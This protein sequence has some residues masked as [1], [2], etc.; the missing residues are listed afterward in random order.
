MGCPN[1]RRHEFL[2]VVSRAEYQAVFAQVYYAPQN[3]GLDLLDPA[4]AKLMS[5]HPGTRRSR[6]PTSRGGPT[7]CR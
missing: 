6:L 4:I 1:P 5:T 2:D 3:P 7:T